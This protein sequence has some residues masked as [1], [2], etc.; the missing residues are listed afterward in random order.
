[1]IRPQDVRPVTSVA[2]LVARELVQRLGLTDA[3]PSPIAVGPQ[4]RPAR[5][6]P[7][8]IGYRD[9]RAEVGW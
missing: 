2:D 6:L 4:R 7:T 3:R 1:M 5:E 9:A 8:T